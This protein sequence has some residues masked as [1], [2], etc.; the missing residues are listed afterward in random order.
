MITII[1]HY[2]LI[3]LGCVLIG[4]FSYLYFR[5]KSPYLLALLIS[6]ILILI[7]SYFIFKQEGNELLVN[8][9]E[10]EVG[11]VSEKLQFVEF[12][13]STCLACM[14]SKPI[15]E[16]LEE[17]FNDKYD[18]VYLNVKDYEYVDL[19]F[20]LEIQTVPTFVILDKKGEVLFR[21]SGVP[22][23]SDLISKLEQIYS[24]QTN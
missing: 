10:A 6:I 4:G 18:F 14:I 24:D 19:V 23:S 22:Q 16:N 12:F 15:I 3:I 7:T 13:S 20:Q 17:E 2:S 21:S 8:S 9:N 1:N 5:K 11:Y